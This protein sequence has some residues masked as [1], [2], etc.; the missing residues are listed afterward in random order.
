MKKT[1]VQ[2]H[3]IS[4]ESPNLK[5]LKI[6]MVKQSLP[7]LEGWKLGK[8]VTSKKTIT[9][10]Q[11]TWLFAN[12]KQSMKFVTTVAKLAETEGHHPDI[13]I[14][15]NRVTLTLYTHAIGGLSDNDIIVAR[16]VNN[17]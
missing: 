10:L 15:Y 1:P 14:S 6:A 4:C 3:C 12:F 16:L 5:P 8:I 13:A 9:S 2:K 7:K 17:L 11:K